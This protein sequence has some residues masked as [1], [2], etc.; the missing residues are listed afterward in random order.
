MT[1]AEAAGSRKAAPDAGLATL[2]KTLDAQ[3]VDYDEFVVRL[4]TGQPKPKAAA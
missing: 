2:Q 4:A 1:A 3:G